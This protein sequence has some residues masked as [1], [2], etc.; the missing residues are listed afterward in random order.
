MH[1]EEGRLLPHPPSLKGECWDE[2][3]FFFSSENRTVSPGKPLNSLVLPTFLVAFEELLEYVMLERNRPELQQ[4][5]EGFYQR[6][7]EEIRQL[8][9]RV[10]AAFDDD[11][12]RQAKNMQRLLDELYTRREVKLSRAALA[13]AKLGVDVL[14]PALL[15]PEERDLYEAIIRASREARER[16]LSLEERETL[17]KIRPAETITPPQT[18]LTDE[19]SSPS[20]KALPAPSEEAV[21]SASPPPAGTFHGEGDDALLEES[22]PE[23]ES[24]PPTRGDE[25]LSSTPLRESSE[26]SGEGPSGEAPGDELAEEKLRVRFLQPVSPF[27]GDDLEIYGPFE[28]GDEAVLPRSVALVLLDKQLAEQLSEH[29]A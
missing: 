13:K 14:D 25:A 24:L 20:D 19:S 2:N 1:R 12:Y 15:Q 29:N 6:V 28:P 8:Q 4:L 23:E 21:P 11:A 27:V 17:T 22:S 5:P 3:P 9:E 7:R 26:A 10:Q 16:V 18:V